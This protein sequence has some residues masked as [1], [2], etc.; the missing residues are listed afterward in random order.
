[1]AATSP[2]ASNA[3]TSDATSTPTPQ[4][5]RLSLDLGDGTSQDVMTDPSILNLSPAD[6]ETAIRDIGGHLQSLNGTPQG[7]PPSL[8]GVRLSID[9]GGHSQDVMADPSYLELSSADRATALQDI[10]NSPALAPDSP[11]HVGIFRRYG[12]TPR[13]R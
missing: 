11:G 6:R 10:R 8:K 1:M 9:L 12:V 13:G 4:G 2:S 7:T 5:I 3:A